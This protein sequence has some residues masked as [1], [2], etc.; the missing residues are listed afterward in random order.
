M[1]SDKAS[2]ASDQ[3]SR[4]STTQFLSDLIPGCEKLSGQNQVFENAKGI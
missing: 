2:P 3:N 4:H 1:R